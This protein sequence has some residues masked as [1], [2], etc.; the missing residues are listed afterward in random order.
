MWTTMFGSIFFCLFYK[1]FLNFFMAEWIAY[2][3]DEEQGSS[4]RVTGSIPADNTFFSRHL[5]IELQNPSIRYSLREQKLAKAAKKMLKTL[6]CSEN[7][8]YKINK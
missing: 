3:S 1:Q 7:K 6:K 4:K 2:L 5:S 8:Q